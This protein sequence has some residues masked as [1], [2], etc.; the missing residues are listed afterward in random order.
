MFSVTNCAKL[1]E[2]KL[3]SES[4]YDRRDQGEW[5]S[6]VVQ[7]LQEVPLRRLTVITMAM[8]EV[9]LETL[10][11]MNSLQSVQLW[12]VHYSDVSKQCSAYVHWDERSWKRH[13]GWMS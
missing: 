3:R 7:S 2:L 9:D 1:E 4:E 11:R 8:R 6:E 10:L 13:Q 5:F 12:D